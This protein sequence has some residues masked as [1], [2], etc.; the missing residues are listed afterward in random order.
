MNKSLF[1]K[2]DVKLVVGLSVVALVICAVLMLFKQDGK[3]VVVS[4][5]GVVVST[6]SLNDNGTYEIEGYN[7]G[8]NTLVIENGV[9]YMSDAS[10]PDHL[11]MHMGKISKVGQSIICLPN[12]VVV[13]IR[14]SKDVEPEYDTVS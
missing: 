11:C 1:G 5:D 4:V 14:G 2:N 7:K 3:Q 10:C 13:E 12:R 6:Y 9:A 8:L